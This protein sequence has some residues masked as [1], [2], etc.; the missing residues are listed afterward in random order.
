MARCCKSTHLSVVIFLIV[1]IFMKPRFVA[2]RPLADK[3]LLIQ[4]LPRGRVPPSRANPCTYIPGGK[5]RGRCVIAVVSE[6]E[7]S[8]QPAAAPTST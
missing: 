2:G 8:G 1:L 5:S 4:S 3:N 7:I 6:E